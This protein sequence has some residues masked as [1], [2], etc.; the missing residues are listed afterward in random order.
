MDGRD[1]E[2]PEQQ[3]KPSR[4]DSLR[5]TRMPQIPRVGPNAT[6]AYPAL[7]ARPPEPAPEP[8]ATPER[9]RPTSRRWA[10][11]AVGLAVAIA[12]PAGLILADRRE[13]GAATDVVAASSPYTLGEPVYSAPESVPVPTDSAPSGAPSLSASAGPVPSASVPPVEAAATVPSTTAPAPRPTGKANPSGVNLALRAAVSASD[14]EGSHWLP[15]YACDG[16]PVSRWSSGFTDAQW[17]KV[18]LRERWQLSQI[19]LSWENAYAI[20]YRVETSADGKSWQRVY[21]T[22]AGTGGKVTVSLVDNIARY[23]RMA[24]VKRSNQYGYSL[25][26]VEIR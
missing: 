10:L 1:N 12:V 22:T 9:R 26:E 14:S 23:V 16:D 3:R 18:D 17:L 5:L 24:G 13:P 25:Y 6:G 11:I 19:V 15:Q 21:S 8:A 7:T 2:Q 4:A 20:A